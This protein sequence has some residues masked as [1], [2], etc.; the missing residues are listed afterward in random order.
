MGVLSGYVNLSAR[1]SHPYTF[2]AL[3][4]YTVGYRS[5]ALARPRQVASKFRS[6]PD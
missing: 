3:Q 5:I 1:D 4:V 2:T 6:P